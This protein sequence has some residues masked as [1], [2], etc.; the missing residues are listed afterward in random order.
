VERGWQNFC[1]E[2]D[3]D[4]ALPQNGEWAE[5]TVARW[6]PRHEDRAPQIPLVI[7]G[8]EIYEGRPCRDC[9]DP[10]RPGVVVGH[11]R[12]ADMADVNRAVECAAADLDGW[13]SM[14]ARERAALLGKA[15]QEIRKARATHAGTSEVLKPLLAGLSGG[16]PWGG[17]G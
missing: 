2:P 10:S 12:Q 3:T 7:G 13:R 15:A 6:K 5:Q 9:L 16:F 8:E 1:N 14:P 11:Y 4:F 17:A